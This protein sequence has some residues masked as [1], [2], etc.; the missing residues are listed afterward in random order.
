[1]GKPD[2]L[3]LGHPGGLITRSSVVQIYSPLSVNLDI[4]SHNY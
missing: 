2:Y 3:G 1:M 4:F